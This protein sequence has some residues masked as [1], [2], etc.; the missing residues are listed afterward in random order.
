MGGREEASGWVVLHAWGWHDK[1]GNLTPRFER[2]YKVNAIERTLEERDY[3][4]GGG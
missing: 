2:G 3:T 4:L 1:T